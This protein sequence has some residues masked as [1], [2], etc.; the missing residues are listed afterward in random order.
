MLLDS[1]FH[2]RVG[3]FGGCHAPP[4]ALLQPG[5]QCLVFDPRQLGE[6]FRAQPALVK[7]LHQTLPARHRCPHPPQN[8]RFY[9][10]SN[11]LRS[12]CHILHATTLMT[13]L[14]RG[15]PDDAY[16]ALASAKGC[17]TNFHSI[18]FL[19]PEAGRRKPATNRVSRRWCSHLR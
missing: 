9:H 4:T 18:L 7:L 2:H 10:F 14:D 6:L 1:G 8:I 5:S 17:G 15:A 13:P 19:T 3:S 11:S 16:E 12:E